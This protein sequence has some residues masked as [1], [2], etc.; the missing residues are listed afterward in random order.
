ME[1]SVRGL[2]L[3]TYL[4]SWNLPGETEEDNETLTEDGRY[5]GLD[6]NPGARNTEEE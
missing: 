4:L 2:I 1:G 5:P 3:G 6:L